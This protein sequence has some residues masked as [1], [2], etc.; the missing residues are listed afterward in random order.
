M[1]TSLYVLNLN[2]KL[3]PLGTDA[4]HPVDNAFQDVKPISPSPSSSTSISESRSTNVRDEGDQG[5]IVTI[6]FF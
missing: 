5:A 1:N 6:K 2:S 3:V 4:L